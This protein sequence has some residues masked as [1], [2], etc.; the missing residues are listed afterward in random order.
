[1]K[2]KFL[3]LLLASALALT[4][5]ATET[6][7]SARSETS[8]ETKTQDD[9]KKVTVV[10]SFKSKDLDPHN[11]Y[12]PLRTGITETLLKL[13]ENLNL[14]G[15][16][17]E[18]WEAKDA[19]TWVFTIRDGI[20]FQDGTK[21]DATAVKASFERGIADSKTLAKA[22][23]I[24]SMQADG[25]TLTIKTKEPNPALPSELV[26]PY[27]SVISVAAEKK[28]GK[29][30]FNHAPVGTGPFKVK[31]FTP[32]IEVQLERYDGYWAGKPKLKEAIVKFNEDA[33]VR[34]LSLQSKEADIVYNIPAES[35]DAV[36]KSGE[37]QVES[38]PGLRVHF[39][40][41]NQ[42]KPLMQNPKVRMALNALLNRESIAKDVMLGN[43]SPANGPFSS[44][45]PFA[46]KASVEKL[47]VAKA[48]AL[49]EEAGFQAGADGKLVKDGKPLTLELITYKARRE[50][51]LIA[52]LLQSDAA[53]AGV[54]VTIKNVENVDDY[55]KE[56][57]DWDMVTYSN[58]TAPRGDGSYFLNTAFMPE[59]SLNAGGI[60]IPS[61]ND[62][63]KKLN[64]TSDAD[65]RV[66]LTQDAVA[67]I[68]QAIPH[69]YAVYP[70]LIVG[71][72]KRVIGFK[73]GAEEFYILTHALDVK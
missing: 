5:C 33:T 57:K 72:N 58:Q 3:S 56:N 44:R 28:M 6:G 9:N 70:N 16:L 36:K 45:L 20:T 42:H 10:F 30:A 11:I 37:F 55:L 12:T 68:N 34:T 47:D 71:F 31:Q 49:L 53:K 64:A 27:A 29:E 21:L 26:S 2:K 52:Q 14:Q 35:I 4:G 67:V 66:K 38:I 62:I 15:W 48:K 25:Q 1:M 7:S 69:S 22:L 51:P 50:L 39:I 59:G 24:A 41:Y 19:T 32:D 18:K 46:S 17:A 61:L 13:D 60:N 54:T 8:T 40:L 63:V 65:E 43:A 73:P 23:K